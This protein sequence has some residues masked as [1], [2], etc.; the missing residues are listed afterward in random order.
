MGTSG[1]RI[2]R[3]GGVRHRGRRIGLLGGSFNPAHDGHRHISQL[4]LARLGL[5]EVWWLVSPQNPLKSEDGMAPFESRLKSANA[6]ARDRR[7]RV[8]AIEA[9]LGTRYTADTLK[10]LQ[11]RYPA[12]RFVWLMGAD[13]LVQISR[14]RAW[15]QIF[16]TIPIAVF[17]RD[18]YDSKALSERASVRFRHA[19]IPERAARSL[20]D[21]APPAWVF[22]RIKPHPATATA[23][24]QSGAWPTGADD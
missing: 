14:W 1:N 4:A 16:N 13:N 9:E 22:L 3:S 20:P 17:A 2:L 23:L 8:S 12:A 19:R 7:I 5:D 24:R 18:S 11:N 15:T 6:V 10:A 21:A